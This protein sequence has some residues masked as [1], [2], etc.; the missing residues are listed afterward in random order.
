MTSE[1]ILA[2]DITGAGDS[3]VHFAAA[4]KRTAMLLDRSALTDALRDHSAVALSSESRFLAPGAAAGAVRRAVDDCRNAG[5][6]VVFKKVDSTL[7]GNPGAEIEAI[8]DSSDHAAALVCVAMPKTGRTCRDGILLLHGKPIQETDAGRDPFNPVTCSSVSGILAA[9]TGLPIGNVYLDAVRSGDAFLRAA[10]ADLI[11]SG[12][13]IVVADAETDEDL[14]ALG[15]L[16][17]DAELSRDGTLP[18]LL[19]VGAGGLA[20]AFS[21]GAL[22]YAGTRP[23]GRMLAV[24]GSLTKVSLSQ[25]RCAE[26]QGGFHILELDMERAFGD[27]DGEITRLA[28]M[29]PECGRRHILL[30]NRSLPSTG[31]NGG[32]STDDGVRAAEIFGRAAKAICRTGDCSML[33][34]TGGST[35]VAVAAALDLRS[36]TLER[37]CM[38]GVVLS[39]CSCPGMS[40]RWFVSKAGGFGGPDTIVKLAAGVLQSAIGETEMNS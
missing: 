5:A 6:R 3:G 29:L 22:P 30:K 38:P 16:F 19:P 18:A 2:D 32:I 7:R 36:I 17:H 4:G 9:Q 12:K 26:E 27:P 31:A 11:V 25:I 21:G 33:Y 14:A 24:V 8:L 40:L 35:A 34:V 20:E 23:Q 39:S 1:A 10:V 28:A 13:R 37:E 15:R